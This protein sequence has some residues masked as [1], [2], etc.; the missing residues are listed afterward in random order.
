[1][2]GYLETYGAGEEKRER[3]LLWI[4]GSTLGIGL[5]GTILYFSFRDWPLERRVKHFVEAVQRQDYKAAYTYWGCTAEAPCREYNY[6]KFLEDW[7]PKGV[8]TRAALGG[9]VVDSE[10]C[11]SGYIAALGGAGAEDVALWVEQSTRIV[12]YAPWREC[13]EK[14]LRIRKWLK[15]RFGIG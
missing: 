14:K 15:M 2:P 8:Y 5:L 1:M 10:R 11:G 7:G 3:R 6:E 9:K 13:P 4:V 12:G